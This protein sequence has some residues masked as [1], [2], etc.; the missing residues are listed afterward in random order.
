MSWPSLR[1]STQA[2]AILVVGTAV[3][4]DTLIYFLLVPLLPTYAARFA[5]GPMGVGLLV[6]SYSAALL[7]STLPLGPILERRGRRTPMLWGL[8]LMAAT[9]LI[10]AFGNSF[11]LMVGAR[12]LQ[13]VA[14]TITWVTG[15][16]LLADVTPPEHRGRAMGTVFAF[17]N[18]GLVAG[19]PLSGWLC[20]TFGPRSPYVVA[21]GLVLLD[22]VARAALLKDPPR[23]PGTPLGILE[24][25]KDPSIRVLAGA[26]ALGA[27]LTTVLETVLPVHFGNTLGF[28]A[29]FIGLLFG[30]LAG[31]HMATSPLMGALSDRVGR[32]RVMT[33]GFLVATLLVPITGLLRGP[34]PFAVLMAVLGIVV[35]L[36]VSPVPP[37]MAAAVDARGSSSYA[38]VFALLNSAY[39]V[40]MLLGPL[41]GTAAQ[42]A[43]GL[44]VTLGVLGLAFLAFVPRLKAIKT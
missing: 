20:D 29:S 36:C 21:A 42:A 16:A 14:G 19:P 23:K 37:A 12:I 18:F 1:P 4:A 31:G 30:L 39:G 28:K 7:G 8:L 27:A 25:L 40:G 26:M 35:S 32:R 33:T 9:T 5:L 10:F 34:L 13:G 11:P 17:A 24:M 2:S 41:V 44:P 15:M 3:F 38:V 43:F 6:W 22:A